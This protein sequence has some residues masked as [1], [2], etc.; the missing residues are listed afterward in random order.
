MEPSLTA[1]P[2]DRGDQP[3]PPDAGGYWHSLIDEK[4]AG[5]FLGV[6]HR[7]MQKMR[8]RGGGP[9]YIVISTRCLRYTRILLRTWAEQRT[10]ASTADHGSEVAA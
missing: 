8:Q 6:T 2:V 5:E 1:L 7:T 3:P 4:A 9:R 10:R